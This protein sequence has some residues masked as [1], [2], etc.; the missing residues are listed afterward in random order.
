MG[1][2]RDQLKKAKLLSKKD[3]KRLA[4]EERVKKSKVGHEGLAKEQADRAR[5]LEELQARERERTRTAQ[6]EHDSQR[7]ES[8]ERAAC[9]VL[10]ESARAPERG[11]A[12]WYF[13]LGDGHLPFLSL[14]DTQRRQLESGQLCI[15]RGGP[16]GTHTY[17]LLDAKHVERLDAALPGR[18]VWRARA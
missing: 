4:H 6:Q 3:A 9:E 8:A 17:R 7:A 10:L 1:N 11:A 16:E 13:E 15:V 5:E 2:M 14:R 18:V 12:R